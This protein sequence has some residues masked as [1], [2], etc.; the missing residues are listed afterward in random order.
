VTDDRVDRVA[1]AGPGDGVLYRLPGRD[2]RLVLGPQTGSA[3]RMTM[4]IASFPPGS[5][6]PPHTHAAEE[7]VVYVI[8]GRGSLHA[9]GGPYPLEPGVCFSVPPGVEHGA[10][11]TGDEPL[12]LLCVFSPPVTPGS[13]DPLQG[14]ASDARP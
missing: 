3:E 2:W 7:E 1:M 9:P 8:S 4:S 12:D 14:P 11:C 10:V 13:Y 5:A 6:P